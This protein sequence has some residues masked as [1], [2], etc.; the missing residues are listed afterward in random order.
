M[1]QRST[2]KQENTQI[3]IVLAWV[4]ANDSHWQARYA[5]YCNQNA[6]GDK[7]LIRYRDWGLLHYWFRGIEAFAPWVRKVHLVTSGEKPDWLNLEHPKLNWVQHTQFMPDAYLPTF[8]INA[9]ET[10]LHRIQGLSSCFI[11]FNDDN[12]L[13]KPTLATDFFREGLPCDFA[14][15]DPIFPE[16]YPEIFINNTKIINRHFSKNEVIKANLSKWINPKYG[17]YLAKSLLLL[18]WK[19]FPGLLDAH[20]AHPYRKETF[21]EVWHA[22]PHILHQ[23]GLAPFRSHTN[24]NQWLFRFWHV[25][26]GAFYPTNILAQGKTYEITPSTIDCICSAI[27][28]PSYPQICINDSEDIADF[29]AT[30]TRLQQTFEVILPKP[31]SFESV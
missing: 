26:Q 12:F 2:K 8:N 6:E 4:D 24:V 9:I 11:Y 1:L 13:I 20:L 5:S 31:S 23:T 14:I 27:R 15:L 22:E 16:A 3:D 21:E 25:A 7:R 19:K 30:K 29:E 10:N 18:P 17:K 28:N